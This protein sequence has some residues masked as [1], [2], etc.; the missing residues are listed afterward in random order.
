[1]NPSANVAAAA[2]IDDEQAI[3]DVERKL[4]NLEITR[5]GRQLILPEIG[6]KGQTK[7]KNTSV[8]VVG[9]G[10]LGA[11]VTMYLTSCGIG[12]EPIKF[13]LELWVFVT[14]FFFFFLFEGH[15]GIVDYDEVELGNLHRQIIHDEMKMKLPKVVSAA[16]TIKR[17]ARRKKRKKNN[18]SRN[19]Q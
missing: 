4:S 17:F 5:Y 3:Q 15:L 11:P 6:M 1:V 16:E 12:Q 13:S 7:L 10:G 8:L 9:A 14:F 2:W 19:P 18:N